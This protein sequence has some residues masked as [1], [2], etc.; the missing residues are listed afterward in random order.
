M[1]WQAIYT[2]LRWLVVGWMDHCYHWWFYLG[3]PVAVA[4]GAAGGWGLHD[5]WCSWRDKY[6]EK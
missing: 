2:E 1:D 6:K 3:G 5:I 4:L